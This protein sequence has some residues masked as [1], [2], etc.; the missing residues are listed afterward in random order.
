MLANPLHKVLRRMTIKL[1]VVMDPIQSIAYKKDSSL[2]MLVA[3][4]QRGWE[5]HYMEQHDLYMDGGEAMA[6]M[7]PLHVAYDPDNWFGLGEATDRRLA[8]LDVILMRKDPPFDAEYI[9][10]TYML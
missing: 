1:G 4:R 8:D 7:R 5:L 2:A 10:S 6:S 3:A 9:Y